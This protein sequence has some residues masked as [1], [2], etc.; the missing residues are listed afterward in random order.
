MV[1]ACAEYKLP[2][3]AAVDAFHFEGISSLTTDAVR[4]MTRK[5]N[6]L[7]CANDIIGSVA[8]TEVDRLGI[9]IP[10]QVSVTGFDNSPLR[11]LTRPLLTTVS[12]PIGKL[13]A[14]AASNLES[15]IIEHKAPA[16]IV[17]IPGVLMVGESS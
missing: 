9:A 14:A 4:S 7:V 13:A 17:R 10:G 1:A 12:M 5:Y 8:V 11:N 15:Q 3:D 2:F 6:A 16:G